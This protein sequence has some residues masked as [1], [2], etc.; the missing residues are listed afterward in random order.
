MGIFEPTLIK[1]KLTDITP[2]LVRSMGVFS[3]L[4][5]VDNTLA[6]YVSHEPIDGAVDWAREMT[7]AGIKLVI[8]SNNY[9]SRV[10][11]FAKLF[12]LPFIT[13]AVKPLPFGYLKARSLLHVKISECAIIGDQIFTDIVG[14]N[15]CGMK[16]ILLEPVEP[17]SSV[18]FQKRRQVEKHFRDKYRRKAG[19]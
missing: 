4:L 17:E 9:K 7:E 19:S 3:L 15:L 14:A 8:V 13:F 5:D 11:P 10:E 16:S 1:Q 6:S 18:L 12:D 2:Q